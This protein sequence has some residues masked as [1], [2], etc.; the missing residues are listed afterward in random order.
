LREYSITLDKGS[1]PGGEVTFYITNEGTIP[2]ELVIIKTDLAEDALPQ[3]GGVV[4]E[5]AGGIDVI[6]EEEEFD[7]GREEVLQ[8]DLKPGRYV[9]ICNISGHYQLGMHTTLTVGPGQ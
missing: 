5:D 1:V 3:A 6:D 8:S 4:D 2:H 7:P 9:L